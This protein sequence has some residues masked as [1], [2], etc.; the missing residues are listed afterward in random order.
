MYGPSSDPPNDNAQAKKALNAGFWN[1]LSH[2]EQWI[3]ETL[4]D[5]SKSGKSN[6]HARK[7][8]SYVCEMNENSLA[9]I[10]GIFR[11][12]REGREI[13]ERHAYA[14]EHMVRKDPSYQKSTLRQTQVIILPFCDY[15]DCFQAYEGVIQAINEA[16]RNARDLVTDD[17]IQKME[18][19][20]V[21]DD[22]SVS[23]NGASLHPK[24][25][26]KTPQEMINDIEDGIDVNQ[27]EL[28]KR[29]NRARRSPY[30][31]LIVETKSSPPVTDGGQAS[32]RG[33]GS[34]PSAGGREDLH[35]DLEERGV[36]TDIV[37]KL[38]SIFAKSA[39]I[40][41]KAEINKGEDAFYKA[42]GSVS[43]IEEILPCHPIESAQQ[44]IMANDPLYN[45]TVSSFTSADVTHAD[46]A[47]EFVFSNL[48]MHRYSPNGETR[49][50]KE[51]MIGSRSYLIMPSFV[52]SSATSFEM[53]A[54]EVRSIIKTI[55]GLN[56]KVSISLMH[57]EH[58]R[59]EKRAP[60]PVFVLQ[61]YD[62]KN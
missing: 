26:N 49:A 45:P 12:F 25:G 53:F 24:Y 41:K 11:R 1:A 34:A 33:G 4:S 56:E 32:S 52:S 60:M 62:E 36:L 39:A 57:P 6:P 58:V 21:E 23:I 9:A 54:N 31:T 15:F 13:G 43:G 35:N 50:R 55:D 10:A 5:A 46:A 28:E 18:A 2:T 48:A 16:R 20:I 40:H 3:S 29:R 61:W 17:S 44:W 22:W 38:E 14:E 19:S 42:L 51:Y 37:K 30:P 27:M 47:Y 7:E 8:L 59:G